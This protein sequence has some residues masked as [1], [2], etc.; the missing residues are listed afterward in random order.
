MEL[1]VKFMFTLTVGLAGVGLVLK[2]I[3]ET[4]L[5]DWD[6]LVDARRW[7]R[8]YSHRASGIEHV[9]AED[10]LKEI[11]ARRTGAA[12]RQAP[13]GSLDRRRESLRD[14]REAEARASS[15]ATVEAL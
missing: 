12:P 14:M 2:T 5:Y 10:I 15:T 4:V 6:P 3:F 13:A 11:E 9:S 8:R 7:W 1:Y